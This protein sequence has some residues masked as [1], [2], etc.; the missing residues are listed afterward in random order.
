VPVHEGQE[1]KAGGVLLRLDDTAARADATAAAAAARAAEAQLAQARHALDLHPLLLAQQ[2]AALEA[3]RRDAASAAHVADAKRSLAG[4]SGSGVRQEE[5]AAAEEQAK[6]AQAGV[7]AEEK[8]LEALKLRARDLPLEVTRAEQDVAAK[9]AV[10]AKAEYAVEQCAVRAPADGRVL[11]LAVQAGD[12]LGPQPK[13]PPLIFCPARPRVVRAEVEQE[14]AD[15]AAVGQTAL[16]QDDTKGDGR[17]WTG[18]VAR[19]ADWMAPRRSILP[20]PS[21]FFDVR[22]LECVIHLDP[23]QPPLRIGQRVRIRLT[24]G[25]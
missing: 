15:R 11:R 19:L 18:K 25:P 13:T 22:T 23:G 4:V 24:N 9:K 17:T 10:L 1:V 2:E 21:Q 5:A 6:K 12:L 14:F 20:D 3:A 7:R 8:K 16:I